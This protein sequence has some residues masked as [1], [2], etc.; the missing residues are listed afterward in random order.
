MKEFFERP[1]SVVTEHPVLQKRL[2]DYE[3]RLTVQCVHWV[4][5][6]E[7]VE[8]V[9]Q[10]TPPKPKV[11]LTWRKVERRKVFVETFSLFLIRTRW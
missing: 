6:F 3:V 4:L 7:Y 8:Y 1:P 10:F 5:R 9:I 11:V 2:W